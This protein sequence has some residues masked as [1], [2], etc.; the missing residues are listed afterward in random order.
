MNKAMSEDPPH[1]RYSKLM[2]LFSKVGIGPG[3]DVE[4]QDEATRRGLAR[5]AIDGRNLITSINKSSNPNMGKKV[6][7]WSIPPLTYGRLG[8]LDDYL[9]RAGCHVRRVGKCAWPLEHTGRM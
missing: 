1:E 5:A 2:I 9:M 6:N 8:E 7:G 3:Q 4:K